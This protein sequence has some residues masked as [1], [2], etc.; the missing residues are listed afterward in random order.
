[1]AQ[2][3]PLVRSDAFLQK[4]VEA[5]AAHV[6][7]LNEA[8]KILFVSKAWDSAA[9]HDGSAGTQNPWPLTLFKR[10]DDQGTVA[11]DV[12]FVLS[13]DIGEILGGTLSDFHREYSYRDK[14]GQRWFDVHAARL[15]LPGSDR[16][17]VLLSI[18]E[19][20]KERQAAERLC[21]L[22][23][24]LISAQE[25]ERRRIALEL[26]DDLNQRLALLS[27]ELDQISQRIPEVQPDVWISIQNVRARVQE[28]SSAIQKVA[29]QLHPSKLEHVGL[30]AAV[31]SLCEEMARH[32]EIR[33]TFRGRGCPRR[34]SKEVTL[35]LY[36]IAQES[37][38]NVIKHSGSPE[39]AVVLS[40][41]DGIVRLSVSDVGKGFDS[42][43]AKAKSGLGLIGMSERL[44][45]VGGEI[46]ITSNER[47]TKI[48]VSIATSGEH[49][50]TEKWHCESAA[51]LS[52][53]P[54]RDPGLKAKVCQAR[55]T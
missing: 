4:I 11:S 47:G 42:H 22:G 15:E 51:P 32:H 40:A 44:R 1:M 2:S 24:R 28:I 10:E 34:L 53:R 55:V 16:F 33:I 49:P 31:R 19:L 52:G 14:G 26:H 13:E 35:C 18:E 7:V 36:R 27:V 41:T 45:S 3:G 38:R 5:C 48:R 25:D 37:L 43:S 29:Y 9:Q 8:G 30:S 12:A 20:T 23:G 50:K 39:A 21:D 54:R 17:R 6:A 46:S